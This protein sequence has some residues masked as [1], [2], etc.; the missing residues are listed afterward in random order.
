MYFTD[1]TLKKKDEACKVFKKKYLE[2]TIEAGYQDE[3]V[4][5]SLED[6]KGLKRRLL[7]QEK[8]FQ[9]FQERGI[10]SPDK[11][12][13][14]YLFRDLSASASDPTRLLRKDWKLRGSI[15]HPHANQKDRISFISVKHQILEAMKQ[16]YTKDEIKAGIIRSMHSA[17]RLKNVLEMKSDWTYNAGQNIWPKCS[18]SAKKPTPQANENHCLR[19]FIEKQVFRTCLSDLAET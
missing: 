10:R 3:E 11:P 7:Q 8:L 4:E 2:K 9:D 18:I 15:G 16:G 17:S 12:G 19:P 1:G 14:T 13:K 5:R 6:I